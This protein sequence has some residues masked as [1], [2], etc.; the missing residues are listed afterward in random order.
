[1][2]ASPTPPASTT[3]SNSWCRA[4]IRWPMPMMMLIPEAWAGNPLDGRRPQGLL[5]ISRRPDGAVGRP[6]RRRLHRR[7]PDRR[8]A[9]PQR[10]APGALPRHRRRPRHPRLRSRRAAGPG[11]ED[12]QEVAPAAGQD[13][14]DRPG[15]G[16]HR[17]RRG[18][19]V[20]ARDH[21]S[22]QDVAGPHP[23]HPR[24]P[25]AGR[26]ARAAHATCRCSIASRPSA[27]RRKTPSS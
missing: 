5:R 26:A 19:Q 17:L 6:G 27:T 9:R 24:G 21:A 7:P 20:R 2:R 18:D 15:E 22:L 12:R 16:P 13:A 10:P 14:A 3:R 23:D 11:G 8:D 1:M 4:A 25:E